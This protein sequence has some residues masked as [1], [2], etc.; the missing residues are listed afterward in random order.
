[1]LT[2]DNQAFPLT[3]HETKWPSFVSLV[4]CVMLCAMFQAALGSTDS[5]SKVGNTPDFR[6]GVEVVEQLPVKAEKEFPV[7]LNKGEVLE[8][9]VAKGDV[10][11]SVGLYE[12]GGQALSEYRSHTYEPIEMS[13]V[14]ET[15]GVY[16]VKIRSLEKADRQ[17][18]FIL[19]VRK[20]RRATTDDARNSAARLAIATAT[21]FSEEWTESSLG[22][23]I[24]KYAEA[25]T[26]AA[27]PRIASWALRKA[28]EVHFI[29]GHY[30]LALDLFEHAATLSE[31]SHNRQDAIEALTETARLHSLLG[32]N[33]KAQQVLDRVSGFY[34]RRNL[35]N[36][37]RAV[38]HALAQSISRQG[39]VSYSKE[40][41]LRSLE[42]FKRAVEL[43]RLTPD[44]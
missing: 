31:R 24:D 16:L 43:F 18:Q 5:S 37:T 29:Q 40:D 13:V 39:E 12:P 10:N 1:M 20:V 22:T 32:N 41:P 8:F 9:A 28:G 44:R 4:V 42:Y 2:R 7:F 19:T 27:D 11:L 23:A 25:A 34:S 14:A 3:S 30:K 33:D 17:D 35:Q 21:R 26:L 6:F 36:E 38:R 15:S